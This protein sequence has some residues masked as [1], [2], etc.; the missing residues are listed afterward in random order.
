MESNPVQMIELLSLQQNASGYQMAVCISR[1]SARTDCVVELDE[2]T[3]KEMLAI[4]P[5]SQGR[6]RLSSYTKWDPYRKLHY[7]HLS[8]KEGDMRYSLYFACSAAFISE[9]QR[10]KEGVNSEAGEPGILSPAM[11]GWQPKLKNISKIRTGQHNRQIIVR[12]VAF[13]LFI[14]IAVISTSDRLFN[15]EDDPL[16]L[17]VNAASS[18]YDQPGPKESPIQDQLQAS[19]VVYLANQDEQSHPISISTAQAAIKDEGQHYESY[20]LEGDKAA[21]SLPKG[22]VALTFDDGPSAY[23]E[24]IVDIL[25]E[26]NVAATFL[27]IGKNTQKYP[28]AVTY[29]SDRM[30]SV[31]NHSW[32]HSNLEQLERAAKVENV[33]FATK[34]IEKLTKQA[35]TIFRPPYGLISD[36]LI[37]DLQKENMKVLMWNRD[38]EDWKAA[39]SEAIIQYFHKVDPSGGIYVLHEKKKT[40]EALP[41][42]IKYLKEQ[43]LKF[44]IFE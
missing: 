1:E 33:G 17:S 24:E 44:V 14:L 21:Y 40:V 23:T 38:P 32:D 4:Y 19:T 34:A 8:Y 16:R 13:S 2:Y 9:L 43:D 31:G 6:I 5:Q 30:M 37:E 28:E 20:E 15:E 42:I 41:A 12:L 27:F 22:Y 11:K 25:K 26:Q 18:L 36:S 35:N 7:S 39:S 3:Y 10:L 29:A